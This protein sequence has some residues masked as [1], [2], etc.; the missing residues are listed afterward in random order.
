MAN[1]EITAQRFML[2]GIIAEADMTEEV[3]D[4]QKQFL[5]ILTQAK[6]LGEKE[7]GAAIM[8]ITL[9]GLDLAEESGV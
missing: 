8:A 6:E 2:K 9:V 1:P 7:H 4:F 5:N 3:A